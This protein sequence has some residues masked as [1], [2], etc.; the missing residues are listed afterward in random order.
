MYQF[1]DKRPV[2]RNPFAFR[3]PL[4]A[5]LSIMHRLSGLAMVLLGGLAFV[6]GVWLVTV[7]ESFEALMRWAASP[8]AKIGWTLLALSFWWHWLTGLRHLIVEHQGFDHP[9]KAQATRQ[10]NHRSALV[11]IGVFVFGAVLIVLGVWQ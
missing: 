5:L 8:W 6:W 2:L 11:L 10:A 7:P 1:P 9:S 3:Y 4:N